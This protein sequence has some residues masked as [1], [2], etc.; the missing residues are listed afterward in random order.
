MN[1]NILPFILLPGLMTAIAVFISSRIR[2]CIISGIFFILSMLF[3]FAPQL[4]EILE[5]KFLFLHLSSSSYITGFALA[6]TGALFFLYIAQKKDKVF[7][8]ICIWAFSS[9]IIIVLVEN[10]FTFYLFWE[11]LAL[12]TAGIIAIGKKEDS[13]SRAFQYLLV[14]LGGGLFFF[15]GIIIQYQSSGSL[16]LTAS[17]AGFPYF[18]VS[19]ILKTAALPL[20]FWLPA[21]Y[22]HAT[23]EGSIALS[24]LSTKVGVYA[25][26]RIAGSSMAVAYIGAFSALFGVIMALAQKKMRSLLSY[27]IIS[28]VGYMVA[29][30]GLGTAL[31][32]DGAFFHLLNHMLYKGLLFMSAAAVIYTT[33]YENLK[34][35][36][37][38]WKKLPLITISA[39]V[40]ALAISGVPP[41]NGFVSKAMLKYGTKKESILSLILLFASA[42]TALSF[43]KFMYFGFFRSS[44]ND[45]KIKEKLSFFRQLAM[46]IASLII[47]VLGIYP[48]LVTGILPHQSTLTVYKYSTIS[49]SLFT[50]MGGILI[51]ILIKPVLDPG[52]KMTGIPKRVN[53]ISTIFIYF[54]FV[55]YKI[56][57][58]ILDLVYDFENKTDYLILKMSDVFL[59][60]SRVFIKIFDQQ[61]IIFFFEIIDN[62]IK[63]LQQILGKVDFMSE[64][65]VKYKIK[66]IG[67]INID[68][69]NLDIGIYIYILIF[70][71]MFFVISY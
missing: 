59:G 28:Q 9:A 65:G 57:S 61:L 66:K 54:Y 5:Y 25:L 48:E 55:F 19:I 51:F 34:K 67:D 46:M 18:L 27:H 38:L 56:V 10:F 62:K 37:G 63:T 8:I 11:V 12:S 20:Y 3:L 31:S 22:P 44:E 39:L 53:S 52:F 24:A 50:V 43:S 40:G 14:H 60:F 15:L 45:I 58:Y 21:S 68:I 30:V 1:F 64:K 47:L 71:F 41:F 16:V 69:N 26:F 23:P 29:G 70:M 7:N 32:V 42:G 33:G 2:S 4:G 13:L 17:Q 36:G 35:L 6:L 49:T